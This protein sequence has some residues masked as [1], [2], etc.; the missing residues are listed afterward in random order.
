MHMTESL[1]TP[2]KFRRRA[3]ARPDEVLDAALGLFAAQGYAR[4]SVEQ[5]ARAAGLSKGA[6]YLYFPSK[7]SLLE[8]LVRRAV[9][10]VADEALRRIADYRGDPRPLIRQVF[11]F[12]RDS[13]ADPAVLQVP[14]LVIREAVAAP[15]IARMYRIEVLD[16][17]LPAFIGLIAQAVS[18]GHIRPVDPELVLR[19][20]LGPVLLHL[21]LAEV[22]AITPKGGLELDL[23]ID[24]H[25][26]L[27][28]A[29]LEPEKGHHD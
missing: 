24:T 3:K 21:V 26:T 27:L 28:F 14:K 2:P 9:V 13:L 12:L 17:V 8:G 4:T 1:V 16:R 18:A 10:P 25:L 5:I 15:D 22:F 23:M 6:V 19:C 20:L 29:G 7:Q 11:G